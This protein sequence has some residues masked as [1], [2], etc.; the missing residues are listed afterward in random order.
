MGPHGVENYQRFL[1]DKNYWNVVQ[2]SFKKI[3]NVIH[4]KIRVKSDAPDPKLQDEI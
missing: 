3:S 1:R 4:V 2:K